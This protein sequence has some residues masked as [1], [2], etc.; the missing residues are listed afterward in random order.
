M[1]GQYYS[2]IVLTPEKTHC[3]GFGWAPGPVPLWFVISDPNIVTIITSL[4]QFRSQNPIC[5]FPLFLPTILIHSSFP[6]TLRYKFRIWVFSHSLQFRSQFLHSLI[7]C[8]ATVRRNCYL[9]YVYLPFCPHGAN[10]LPPDRFVLKWT[11][12]IFTA[13]LWD[14]PIFCLNSTKTTYGLQGDLRKFE[15]TLFTNITTVTFVISVSTLAIIFFVTVI[16][17]LQF[18]FPW[19]NSHK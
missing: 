6:F 14:L 18:F 1:G 8:E 19:R 3:T 17:W 13:M 16:N 11:L 7:R 5:F 9:P 4:S 15:T 12:G 2:L 10:L